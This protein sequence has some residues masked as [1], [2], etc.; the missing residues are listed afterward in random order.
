MGIMLGNLTIHEVENRLNFKLSD[1]IERK[2]HF[3]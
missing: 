3:V 2:I 1:E